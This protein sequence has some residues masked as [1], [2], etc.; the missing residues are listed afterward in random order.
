MPPSEEG[1]EEKCKR[2]N[3][4]L[5]LAYEWLVRIKQDEGGNPEP[6]AC[7]VLFSLG[8]VTA[9][10]QDKPTRELSGGWRMRV[11]LSCT[12]FADQALLLLDE[13]TSHLDLE[14]VLWLK[15]YL[16]KDFKGILDIFSHNRHFLNEVVTNVVHFH[17]GKLTTYRGDI[18]NFS[19]VREENRKRQN[20]TI[21]AAGG[22]AS[23]SP[24]YIDLHAE[25]GENGVKAS[26]QRQSRMKKLDKLGVMA[27]WEGKMFKAS[28]DGE[29]KE[30]EEYE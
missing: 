6:R 5:A 28:Y 7:R 17:Q 20:P 15:Q 1:A 30:I 29:A 8:F 11:S 2:L 12:L 9:K 3:A 22:Q 13:P 21:R 18:S 10:M 4:K 14:A 27:A 19:A 16:T 23:A 25:L 24:E 26:R